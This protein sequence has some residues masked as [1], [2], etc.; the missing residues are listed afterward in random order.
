MGKSIPGRFPA[1]RLT[2]AGMDAA[3]LLQLFLRHFRTILIKDNGMLLRFFDFQNLL[4]G[5]RRPAF[6]AI[7]D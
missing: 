5:K 3:E 4:S 7:R 1:E 2:G 6:S